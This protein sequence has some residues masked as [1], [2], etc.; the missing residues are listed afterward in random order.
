MAKKRNNKTKKTTASKVA[1]PKSETVPTKETS[2]WSSN[3]IG[4]LLALFA[5]VLYANTIGHGYAFDDSIV[6]TQ[7]NFTQ[8][9]LAGIPDL[10]T[11]DFF[12]GIYGGDGMELTGGRY[13]PLS[14]IMFAIE[15]QFFGLNPMVGH[16]INVLLYALTAFMLFRVLRNWLQPYQ[17]SEIMAAI[18][19]L[20]FIA[21][22][23]HTEVV[24]NIKSRDEILSLL[25]VL[26][27]LQ[28][29]YKIITSQTPKTVHWVIALGSFFL[30]LLAKETAFTFVALIPLGLLALRKQA[31]PQ[32]IKYSVPFWGVAIAYFLLR[33]AMVGG[34][35]S[36]ENPDIMEN[37]FY[38]TT[39]S[40]K[41][42][43]IGLI[44]WY[45]MSLVFYPN[46]L[47]SDYS[48][49]QIPLVELTD[50]LALLGWSIYIGLGLFAILKI[51]NKNVVAWSILLYLAPLSLVANVLFN[52][53]APMGE[54]FLYF[55]SLGFTLAIAYLLVQK[56]NIIDWKSLQK[57]PVIWLA[58][59]A[60]TILF[61]FKTID[62]NKDWKDNETL[63]TQDINSSPN[64][65]KMQYYYANTLLVKY[66]NTPDRK[67]DATLLDLAEKHF[68]LSYE[69]NNKFLHS[70]Y[71]L[72]MVYVQKKK[73]KEALQWLNYT[74][75]LQPNYAKAHEQ[76]VRVY[77]ELL[78]QPDNAMKHLEL[79]LANPAGKTATNYQSLGIL[80]AMKG[81][82]A[83]AEKAFLKSIELDP[84]AKS[85]QNLGGLYQQAGQPEKAK[86]YFEK[87]YQIDPSLRPQ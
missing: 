72:G 34:L 36:V 45:Y 52:I 18:A 68:L 39:F 7:N 69:I 42:G 62:R 53:G 57:K 5:F 19:S 40:Q 71:N 64:S 75:E 33:M 46:P 55:S 59:A 14:L 66:L 38:G 74:L 30:S 78:N 50:P 3:K 17:G 35:G 6:I 60:I 61:S 63:F 16:F 85:Y 37:P 54:R 79:V 70:T 73:A 12:V 48:R 20:L 25:L 15:Y 29:L 76:L 23:I 67:K 1:I 83:A 86:Q 2:F 4:I 9:G 26:F 41:F 8:Q 22:P 82:T 11:K 81:N 77:G 32:A 43:T 21:H 31:L 51:W 87:S 13:R 56:A 65:A 27:A 80:N 44:L 47:S 84:S 28:Y 24:A 10:L 49:E 58:L